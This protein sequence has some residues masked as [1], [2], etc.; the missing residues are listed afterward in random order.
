MPSM[1]MMSL[2]R[3]FFLVFD[4]V[5]IDHLATM[6]TASFIVDYYLTVFGPTWTP[7]LRTSDCRTWICVAQAMAMTHGKISATEISTTWQL[8]TRKFTKRLLSVAHDYHLKQGYDL[9]HARCFEQHVF[10]SCWF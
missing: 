3:Y 4:F 10:M 1:L 9:H 5:L 6:E 8:G 7:R 2:L